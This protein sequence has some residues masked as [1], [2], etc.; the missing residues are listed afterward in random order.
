MYK[1]VLMTLEK[2]LNIEELEYIHSLQKKYDCS[3]SGAL[4]LALNIAKKQ[5]EDDIDSKINEIK[6]EINNIKSE[7]IITQT[8]IDTLKS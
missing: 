2:R 4:R 1:K 8:Q 5:N 6:T 7:I 3:F